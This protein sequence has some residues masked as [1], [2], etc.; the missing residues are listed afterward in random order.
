[1]RFAL[2]TCKSKLIFAFAT[3]VSKFDFAFTSCA[4]KIAFAYVFCFRFSCITSAD[5]QN[6]H[7]ALYLPHNGF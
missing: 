1:M 3:C 7:N 4:S 6:R 2:T 5:S